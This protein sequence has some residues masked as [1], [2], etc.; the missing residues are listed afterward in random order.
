M[1]SS[2]KAR[3]KMKINRITKDEVMVFATVLEKLVAMSG[4][5]R[6][7]NPC[8]RVMRSTLEHLGNWKQAPRWKPK[9]FVHGEGCPGQHDYLPV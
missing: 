1:V 2:S 7:S 6:R 4:R 9:G 8:W 3:F 5:S